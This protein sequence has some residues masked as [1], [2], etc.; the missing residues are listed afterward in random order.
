MG[1]SGNMEYRG[2]LQTMGKL[3][4]IE[5]SEIAKWGNR[6]KRKW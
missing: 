4:K 5:N 1:E 6:E 2:E 3:E